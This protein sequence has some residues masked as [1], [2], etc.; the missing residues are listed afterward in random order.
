MEVKQWVDADAGGGMDLDETNGDHKGKPKLI[1]NDWARV[2]GRL[3]SFNNKRHVGAHNIRPITDKMDITYH[4]LE[5]TFVHLYFTKGPL[6]RL[7]D[8]GGDSAAAV[9]GQ[10]AGSRQPRLS[11][12]AQRVLDTIK[13][14][15]EN[16]EGLHVQNIAAIMGQNVAEVVKGGNELFELSLIY[17]TMNEDTWQVMET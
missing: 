2:W 12:L 16:N 10:S 14:A 15:P 5:S 6:D 8:E 9:N 11:P 1:E 3:K 17:T 13:A 4:L 7:K